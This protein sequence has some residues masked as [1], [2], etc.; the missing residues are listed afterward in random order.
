LWVNAVTLC[1]STYNKGGEEGRVLVEVFK[2]DGKTVDS[3]NLLTMTMLSMIFLQLFELQIPLFLVC[4]VT[5]REF[6]TYLV[7]LSFSFKIHSTFFKNFTLI[8]DP[9]AQLWVKAVTLWN[10]TCST[11]REEGRVLVEVFKDD[12][13]TVGSPN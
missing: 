13:K 7:K 6:K 2:D 3:S 5:D 12:G 8:V 1:H 4:L 11:G 10:I 9:S